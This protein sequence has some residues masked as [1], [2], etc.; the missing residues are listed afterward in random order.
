MLMH[1][2][3]HTT[4]TNTTHLHVHTC[5]YHTM[6]TYTYVYHTHTHMY[7]HA[8][9]PACLSHPLCVLFTH[10]ESRYLHATPRTFPSVFLFYLFM[11]CEVSCSY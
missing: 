11:V 10:T 5:T 1:T 9:L 6:H 8:V 2:Y 4:H 7:T 3:I